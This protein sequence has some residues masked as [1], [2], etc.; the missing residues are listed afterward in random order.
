MCK[1][2]SAVEFIKEHPFKAIF[3]PIS[4][5]L[6]KKTVHEIYEEKILPKI[7]SEKTLIKD[8]PA[9]FQ[10][11]V[12][13]ATVTGMGAD[14]VDIAQT[15]FTYV[16]LPVGKMLG[17]IKVK[18]VPIEQIAKLPITKR[19]FKDIDE[20]GRYFR[21]FESRASKDLAPSVRS[22][23]QALKGAKPIRKEQEILYAA[24]RVKRF[25]RITARVRQV[26]KL[27]FVY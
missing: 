13:G 14:V 10:P 26:I 5:T 11:A 9:E 19:F 12:Y 16:P 3:Q 6:G 8:V 27:N 20:L 15:P 18:G 24:E 4:K 2:Y 7:V 22:I 21:W 23:I 1:P 25:G 17:R